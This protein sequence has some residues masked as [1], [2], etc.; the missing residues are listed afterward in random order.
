[1]NKKVISAAAV[2]IAVPFLFSSASVLDGGS[3]QG[4][5]AVSA[6]SSKTKKSTKNKDTAYKFVLNTDTLCLHGDPD[7]RAA[8]KINDENYDEITISA[9]KF[10]DYSADGYWACG[11]KGCNTKEVRSALPKPK[12]E[13]K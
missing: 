11:V 6:L 7:C 10:D 12:K 3:D 1:M 4:Y 2:I 5:T 13:K 9:D 8:K